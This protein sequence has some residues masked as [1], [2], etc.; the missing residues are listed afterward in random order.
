M[1]IYYFL[2]LNSFIQQIFFKNIENLTK[3]IIMKYTVYTSVIYGKMIL[4]KK[5]IFF[6]FYLFFK[7]IN[8]IPRNEVTSKN[9]ILTPTILF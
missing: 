2:A 5:L 3:L 7:V 4:L 8:K 1:D 6:F 9:T